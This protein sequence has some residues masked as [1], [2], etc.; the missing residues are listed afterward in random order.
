MA[1]KSSSPRLNI[2]KSFLKTDAE[3]AFVAIFNDQEG[4]WSKIAKGIG[5]KP[6]LKNKTPD[7]SFN[8][9]LDSH[10]L[11]LSPL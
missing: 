7:L 11:F 2:F 1:D 9:Q 3:K 4:D 8:S 6:L 5:D 10:T